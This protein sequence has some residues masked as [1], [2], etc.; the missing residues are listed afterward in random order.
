MYYGV[1]ITLSM[2]ILPIKS[3]YLENSKPMLVS[4]SNKKIY[5]KTKLIKY[6]FL[7]LKV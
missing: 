2:R 6:N 7:P 5:S 1:L 4:N 3:S